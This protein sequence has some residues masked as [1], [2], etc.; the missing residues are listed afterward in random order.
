MKK[1][2]NIK[3]GFTLTELLVVIA[4]MVVLGA[5]IYLFIDPMELTRKNRDYTRISDLTSLNNAINT[6]TNEASASGS[7]ILCTETTAPCTG[8]SN[9]PGSG[10]RKTDGTGWVKVNFGAYKGVSLPVL[11]VDPVNNETYHYTYTT[12][13]SGDKWEI[14]TIFESQKFQ[15]N[16][17]NDGGDNDNI[18]EVGSDFTIIK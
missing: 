10:T 9:T 4:I 7:Q 6:I 3:N 14:N 1:T 13:N 17:A 12:N 11:P 18:Y 15:S 2:K 8:T 5:V 16:M